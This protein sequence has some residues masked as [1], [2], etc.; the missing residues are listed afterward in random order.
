VL[1]I[2]DT[3]SSIPDYK[4]DD[5]M[6]LKMNKT[7]SGPLRLSEDVIF[8]KGSAVIVP[9]SSPKK[10]RVLPPTPLSNA[11]QQIVSSTLN[12]G[13]TAKKI[14]QKKPD[15]S[16]TS[17]SDV[18]LHVKQLKKG[19]TVISNFDIE[20]ETTS[21]ENAILRKSETAISSKDESFPTTPLKQKRDQITKALADS[22][23]LTDSSTILGSKSG[24]NGELSKRA[25]EV[26]EKLEEYKA[27][28]LENSFEQEDVE[29]QIEADEEEIMPELQLLDDKIETEEE[30]VPDSVIVPEVE[31]SLSSKTNSF[32]PGPQLPY[33]PRNA[34]R[35]NDSAAHSHARLTMQERE[36]SRASAIPAMS[37]PASQAKLYGTIERA[38]SAGF[39]NR[40]IGGGSAQNQSSSSTAGVGA[41]PENNDSS[42][43]PGSHNNTMKNNTITNRKH[44]NLWIETNRTSDNSRH[45]QNIISN[46][47][48]VLSNSF[49]PAK[50][51]AHS[52]SKNNSQDDDTDSAYESPGSKNAKK[53]KQFSTAV[54]Q[55]EVLHAES[56]LSRGLD[57]ED[58]D[59]ILS[60]FKRPHDSP[61]DVLLHSDGEDE[62]GDSSR[63][64]AY[65]RTKLSD[66]FPQKRRR[67]ATRTTK[68]RN[69]MDLNSAHATA[70]NSLEGQKNLVIQQN[71]SSSETANANPNRET[72]LR[73]TKDPSGTNLMR[74]TNLDRH[75][76]M[77]NYYCNNSS[78]ANNN[79]ETRDR[80]TAQHHH[81]VEQAL[82]SAHKVR[83]NND[84]ANLGGGF[85]GNNNG[86]NTQ[87]GHLT[88][89]ASE[90]ER[91]SDYEDDYEQNLPQKLNEK[92]AE[93]AEMQSNNEL[94][95]TSTNEDDKECC[96]VL[97]ENCDIN[98]VD[99]SNLLSPEIEAVSKKLNSTIVDQPLPI[100]DA[101]NNII[102]AEAAPNR[103][104]ETNLTPKL[105]DYKRNIDS[106]LEKKELEG[107]ELLVDTPDKFD[108]NL[109]ALKRR[110]LLS[111][112]AI[113][114][115]ST[116]VDEREVLEVQDEEE[117][118]LQSVTK[119]PDMSF[120]EKWNDANMR[121]NWE[122]S[123]QELAALKLQL[124]SELSVPFS[125]GTHRRKR[126][127]SLPTKS[128]S[129]LL[130]ERKDMKKAD[131]KENVPNRMSVTD[132]NSNRSSVRR[133]IPL[134]PAISE[135]GSIIEVKVAKE[136]T[137]TIVK[138]T[139]TAIP[140]ESAVTIIHHDDPFTTRKI[141][142]PETKTS[143]KTEEFCKLMTEIDEVKLIS[144]SFSDF[145][146]NEEIAS[147]R[148]HRAKSADRTLEKYMI[149]NAMLNDFSVVSA[150]DKI[151]PNYFA[152]WS[153][154]NPNC[155]TDN[156]EHHENDGCLRDFDKESSTIVAGSCDGS[157][158][159][160][161]ITENIGKKEVIPANIG[162]KASSSSSSRNVFKKKPAKIPAR[163][164][165]KDRSPK[166]SSGTTTN[167]SPRPDTFKV[168][169]LSKS[170]EA[171]SSRRKVP[172]SVLSSAGKAA[173]L[174]CYNHSPLSGKNHATDA[175][176]AVS[177][178]DSAIISPLSFRNSE[179]PNTKNR[180]SSANTSA[181]DYSG[182]EQWF[183][184][185]E[186]EMLER[187]G[188][189]NKIIDNIQNIRPKIERGEKLSD[190]IF[191]RTEAEIKTQD[192]ERDLPDALKMI[193]LEKE[194]QRKK[195][196]IEGQ[197]PLAPSTV[198]D[199]SAN[200]KEEEE[201]KMAEIKNLFG[202]LLEPEKMPTL[203]EEVEAVSSTKSSAEPEQQKLIEEIVT[204]NIVSPD[205]TL[206]GE[207]AKAYIAENDKK[208][209][210]KTSTN[211]NVLSI[212]QEPDSKNTSNSPSTGSSS[213]GI[214]RE[215][216]R[217]QPK[218]GSSKEANEWK[219]L[220][221]I[222]DFVKDE[223]S[224]TIT[225][226]KKQS[227]SSGAKKKS[228]KNSENLDFGGLEKWFND[229]E[230]DA[231]RKS[232]PVTASGHKLVENP[233]E[234]P[235]IVR[236]STPNFSS[237]ANNSAPVDANN[238]RA[239][240][241]SQNEELDYGG[242]EKWF[243]KD[244]IDTKLKK[245]VEKVGDSGSTLEEPARKISNNDSGSTLDKLQTF[246]YPVSKCVCFLVNFDPF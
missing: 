206:G 80:M 16:P 83:S 39:S 238:K 128:A 115:A 45:H 141:S 84:L 102:I 195:L 87:F 57:N 118:K 140:E 202:N 119:R 120:I 205:F 86:V 135:A 78:S 101:V 134:T 69:Y 91:D 17:A 190:L 19:E 212:N 198:Y 194:K 232:L 123:E 18:Q 98:D 48:I 188:E 93:L 229:K 100:P 132:K 136:A 47:I 122:L 40:N 213:L 65:T 230:T 61:R 163:G 37:N 217:L 147:R 236:N 158:F 124:E 245:E 6:S 73:M 25:A 187:A 235:I 173:L 97:R 46:N 68:E 105:S 244:E 131:K 168:K 55:N 226:G 130:R 162:E 214:P 36:N 152:S 153:N 156:G 164:R 185:H 224:P 21:E 103:V 81:G 227:S 174:R 200:S 211:N 177:Q 191:K 137:P 56:L 28:N 196:F 242:L 186:K 231:L 125:F 24:N 184:P 15:A 4:E 225:G 13:A 221:G 182:L 42:E 219:L 204:E 209:E 215:L 234:L 172:S 43:Q 1:A 189:N 139:A 2:A 23:P 169:Y 50:E 117:P 44:N 8:S 82:L 203:V 11:G 165:S 79:R 108:E 171:S 222:S 201:N 77:Q 35:K 30:T 157:G 161:F 53:K 241:S 12:G 199:S 32:G 175:A 76:A 85:C 22:K 179:K 33:N 95:R 218:R 9:D 20:D 246:W 138:S 167:M 129:S 38:L 51:T 62:N 193:G 52:T 113:K 72:N 223:F 133:I 192:L 5:K 240:S 104:F 155:C 63:R 243:K 220:R 3:N 14:S 143:M 96:M 145:S 89:V 54:V 31:K 181:L 159:R 71:S 154:Y 75:T 112:Q 121:K 150:L 107:N 111:T 237:T 176:Y 178:L 74:L 146:D 58:R 26:R 92:L 49:D 90:E 183:K 148:K 127:I 41:G 233:N 64:N 170:S 109:N 149:N 216:Q 142:L 99:D 7:E 197:W 228:S 210:E 70:G 166:E 106:V 94:M 29:R 10:S 66:F 60:H 208:I 151:N 180:N 34:Q 88:V 144:E 110:E 67:S 114:G 116:A 239:S 207:I 126:S 59:R 160:Y 27:S